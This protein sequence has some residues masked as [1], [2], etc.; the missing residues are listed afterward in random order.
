MYV[1]F[2]VFVH[3]ISRVF[4]FLFIC[5]YLSISL[6]SRIPAFELLSTA[7]HVDLYSDVAQS[8]KS[9]SSAFL[10]SCLSFLPFLSLSSYSFPLSSP[11]SH[12][13][14]IP[15]FSSLLFFPLLFLLLIC[16]LLSLSLLLFLSLF[17]FVFVLDCI[18]ARRYLYQY[19]YIQTLPSHLLLCYLIFSY[20]IHCL[21]LTAAVTPHTT[22]HT[23]TLQYTTPHHTQ[24]THDTHTPHTHTIVSEST[25]L[26]L[27]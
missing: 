26:R 9:C 15:P 11:L 2:T 8:G 17:L 12:H 21:T 13:S 23:H 3:F 22:H 5:L 1:Q 25:F 4:L 7:L 27:Y 18:C 6:S 24:Q 10:A 19:L 14:I 16:V 20:L